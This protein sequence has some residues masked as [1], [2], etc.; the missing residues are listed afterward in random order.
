MV[1]L[2]SVAPARMSPRGRPVPLPQQMPAAAAVAVQARLAALAEMGLGSGGGGGRGSGGQGGQNPGDPGEDGHAG[3][4]SSGFG[5][6][7]GGGGAHGS[8]SVGLPGRR[9]PA[10]GVALA[11]WVSELR[12]PEAAAAEPAAGVWSSM[13]TRPAHCFSMPPAVQA[14]LA[15]RGPA[16]MAG[17]VPGGSGGRGL[18]L[19]HGR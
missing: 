17:A 19:G 3:D 4:S 13:A 7:G 16:S 1:V 12:M 8:V 9:P 11:V 2:A 15:A 10:A 6:G 5:G 18:H 14:A